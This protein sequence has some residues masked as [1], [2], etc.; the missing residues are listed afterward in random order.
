[1]ETIVQPM[2]S[3]AEA[4]ARVRRA[5]NYPCP[6]RIFLIS[7]L[8]I[9]STLVFL[10]FIGLVT[11]MVVM[12]KRE[13]GL[14]SIGALGG[15]ALLRFVIFI[16]APGLHC[17]LCHGT[18][19]HSRACRK[20]DKGTKLP[21]LSHRASTALAVFFTGRFHCMYCGTPFRVWR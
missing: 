14:W 16:L 12:E 18:V 15:F 3:I 17:T 6:G 20:H 2:E 21:L 4:P 9:L 19:I 7:F 13:L 1:M 5:R 11:W 10:T 8:W